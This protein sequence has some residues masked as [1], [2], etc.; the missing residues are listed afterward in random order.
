MDNVFEIIVFKQKT[1]KEDKKSYDL[2][3]TK[4]FLNGKETVKKSNI[5][6]FL[7]T[8]KVLVNTDIIDLYTTLQDLNLKSDTLDETKHINGLFKLISICITDTGEYVSAYVLVK[9]SGLKVHY[10]VK[11]NQLIVSPDGTITF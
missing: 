10:Q 4:D 9:N 7:Y 1:N 2:L 6:T 11:A 3:S 8:K 5:N